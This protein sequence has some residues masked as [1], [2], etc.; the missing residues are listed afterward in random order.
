MISI[1]LSVFNHTINHIKCFYKVLKFHRTLKTNKYSFCMWILSGCC[2]VEKE[3]VLR[4][5]S[6]L[7]LFLN[8]L[9]ILKPGVSPRASLWHK[10]ASLELQ[11]A[12]VCHLPVTADADNL[13]FYREIT[14]SATSAPQRCAGQQEKK[15]LQA[16]SDVIKCYLVCADRDLEESVRP[17]VPWNEAKQSSLSSY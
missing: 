2:I 13:W 8:P 3:T 10:T 6:F 1:R 17:I 5:L 12:S 15:Q 16:Q 4:I 7:T 11:P 9:L 14:P